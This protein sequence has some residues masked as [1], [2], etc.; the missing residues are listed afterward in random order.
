ML[1][2]IVNNYLK[3]LDFE[4]INNLEDI[5][6]LMKAHIGTFPFSSV[7]VLLKD[8]IS[9]KLDAIYNK[10]VVQKRGAYCFEHNKLF[11]KVLKHLG[12]DVEFYLARVVNNSDVQA[13]Q[14]H[15]F[16]VLTYENEKYL[17]DVGFGFSSASVPVKFSDTNS[18]SYFDIPYR[19]KKNDDNTFGFEFLKDGEF[20]T[21]YKF[22]L[23][24]CYEIDFELGHFYSHKHPKAVF[25]NNLVCSRITKD[26]LYSLRNNIY[27]KF[28]KDSKEDIA[29]TSLGQ[30]TYILEEELNC[31]YTHHEIAF[32]YEN[33]VKKG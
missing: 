7:P 30:F 22:D 13:A 18:T 24:K 31:D 14:T 4:T 27:Q 17:I 5:G 28:Y 11:F 10:I 26:I 3:V 9:L 1:D 21:M 6:N 25:V 23:N 15:R 29:I 12:F 16:T 2:K 8:G 33:Y 19:I 20:Y 32:I